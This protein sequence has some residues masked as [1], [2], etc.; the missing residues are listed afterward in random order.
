MKI[1]DKGGKNNIKLLTSNG[2]FSCLFKMTSCI[3]YSIKFH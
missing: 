3:S 2:G 1:L